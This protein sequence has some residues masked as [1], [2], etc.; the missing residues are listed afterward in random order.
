MA[1]GAEN[2]ISLY[3]RPKV[4]RTSTNFGRGCMQTARRLGG[5][6]AHLSLHATSRRVSYRR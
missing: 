3:D 5:N 2:P 4:L 1:R 6:R